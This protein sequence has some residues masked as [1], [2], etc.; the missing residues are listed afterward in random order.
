MQTLSLY[1]LNNLVSQTIEQSLPEEV[2]VTG[3][4][5]E[6]RPASGG[7]FFGELIQR[8]EETGAILAKARITI[9]A[10]TYHLLR[11][12]FEQ[13][14]GQTLHAGINILVCARISFHEVYGYSLNI[15]DID[16]RFTLGETEQRKRKILAKLQEEGIID[17]NRTLPLPLLLKRIAVISS[18][19]AAGYGDFCDQLR[20]NEYGLHFDMQLFPAIMQGE[21]VEN[22]ILLALDKVMEKGG[23]DAVVI[24]R[25]GGA[26]SDLSDFDTYPLAAAIAQYELP[27]FI[28]IGHDRDETI[29]DRVANRSLKTPTAVAAFLIDH[30]AEQLALLERITHSITQCAIRTLDREHQHL[31]HI[32]AT[33]P[34]LYTRVREREEYRLQLL[35]QRTSSLDPMLLLRRGYSM[36]TMN[37]KLI[38]SSAQLRP[39]D[40]IETLMQDGSIISVVQ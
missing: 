31:E 13:E 20:T 11:Y 6:G 37:G 30:G 38:T 14:T 22:T 4:L 34:I 10:R 26:T 28:G 1:L 32:V 23:F 12:R 7:H 35:E 27:V 21:R 33:I 3:E 25:G 8:S 24:I 9:W 40:R 18:E 17:D 19:H 5:A 2:W 16:P 15:V 39:G 36:T 29:L